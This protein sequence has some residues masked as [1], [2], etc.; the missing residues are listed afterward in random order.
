MTALSDPAP[1]PRHSTERGRMAAMACLL[2]GPAF[3][4]LV[5]TVIAPIVMVAAISLTDYRLG[6]IAVEF[7]GLANYLRLLQDPFFWGALRNSVVY[8]GIVVPVS[9]GGAL[10]LATLLHRRRRSR[11]FYQVVYFLPVTSTLTAM[12]IVWSYV[13]NGNIGPLANLMASIGLPRL[14]FFADGQLAL[15]GLAIIGIWHLLGFNLARH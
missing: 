5:T 12:S 13:L 3:L 10:F 9:V 11:Q 6:R 2:S 14:D 15:V 4:L 1:L 7:I 8:T